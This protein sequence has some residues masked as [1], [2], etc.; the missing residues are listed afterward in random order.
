[1]LAGCGSAVDH[2]NGAAEMIAL[3]GLALGS[4]LAVVV[5]SFTQLFLL[6]EGR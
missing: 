6:T 3:F 1:M 4:M 2:H 5:L